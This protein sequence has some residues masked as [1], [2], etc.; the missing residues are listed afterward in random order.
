MVLMSELYHCNHE[1]LI[2]D[3]IGVF[4]EDDAD[5]DV[6]T[7]IVEKRRVREREKRV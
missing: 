3:V 4:G 6:A 2:E 7:E 5:V 1:D